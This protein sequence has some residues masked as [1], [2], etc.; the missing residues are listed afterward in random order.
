MASKHKHTLHQIEKE[1]RGLLHQVR[2]RDA[3]ALKQYFLL[4]PEAGTFLARSADA[5]YVVARKY[6]FTSWQELKKL[7]ANSPLCDVTENQ[8]CASQNGS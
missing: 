4:G 3:T 7:H 8:S 5:Q 1:A 2:R 6:G